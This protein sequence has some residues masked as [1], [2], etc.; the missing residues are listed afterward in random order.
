MNKIMSKTFMWMTLGL[1]VTFITGFFVSHN[2]PMYENIYR[3]PWY[4]IFAI[5]EVLLVVFLSFK[6]MRMQV[7]TARCTFLLYS[8]VSGITF[9]SIF[10]FYELTSV[11]Y[12]FL[13]T[14]GFFAILAFLGYV[15]KADLTKMRTYV[16]VGLIALLIAGLVNVFLNNS[17]LDLIL[18]IVC[19]LIFVGITMYDVQKLK[20][21]A[22]TNFPEENLIIWGALDLY[23]DFINIFVNMLSLFGRSDN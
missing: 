19:I 1:L 23:L 12:V 6:V 5:F 2:G 9:S 17:L 8:V 4:I 16:I 10:I 13:I 14:A 15:L 11:L 20:R 22:E 7:S 18:S 3:G 21:L